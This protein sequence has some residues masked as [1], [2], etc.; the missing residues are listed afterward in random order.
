MQS[1]E[2]WNNRNLQLERQ[3]L[4]VSMP[5]DTVHLWQIGLKV[6]DWPPKPIWKI[7]DEMERQRA[8]RLHKIKDQKRFICIHGLLRLILSWYLDVDPCSIGFSFNQFGKPRLACMTRL[9]FNVA[10]SSNLVLFAFTSSCQIGVDVERI[11]KLDE[12]NNLGNWF[13]SSSEKELLSSLHS[14]EKVET[15]YKFWVIKEAYLKMLGRG[16]TDNLDN[17]N[18]VP[19]LNGHQKDWSAEVFNPMSDYLAA[20]AIRG[21]VRNIVRFEGMSSQ[22]I[23]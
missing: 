6:E 21:V 4:E 20:L 5:V 11:I 7:L 17:Y 10:H 23:F 19:A 12:L 3:G 22:I 8:L 15:F 1:P 2:I 16:L 14:V 13:L 9:E 18:M